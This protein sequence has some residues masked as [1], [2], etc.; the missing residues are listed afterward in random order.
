MVLTYNDAPAG[1]PLVYN[2]MNV[3]RKM[4]TPPLMPLYSVP[5]LDITNEVLDWLNKAYPMPAARPA[6]TTGTSGAAAPGS[7]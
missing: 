6:G 2:P 5:G 7:H 3:A 1:D 4:Q